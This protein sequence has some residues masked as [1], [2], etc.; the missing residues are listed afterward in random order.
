MEG[1]NTIGLQD[2]RFVH[3]RGFL[4]LDLVFYEIIARSAPKVIY[5]RILK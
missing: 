3:F 4:G 2:R 5:P 1:S